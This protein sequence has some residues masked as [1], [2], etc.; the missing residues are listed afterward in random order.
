M[1]DFKE[2]PM[3]NFRQ[4]VF[5][6]FWESEKLYIS[7]RASEILFLKYRKLELKKDALCSHTHYIPWKLVIFRT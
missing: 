4:N 1:F 3:S 2:F 7:K 5:G 6:T